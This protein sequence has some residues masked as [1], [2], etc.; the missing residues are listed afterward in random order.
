MRR[1]L[2]LIG[3]VLMACGLL[4]ALQ[5]AGI[6][7]WPQESFMIGRQMWITRGSGLAL[8]GLVLIFV[9]RQLL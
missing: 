3:V 2:M 5:G 4:F 1:A 7:A 8:A 6:V 9:A